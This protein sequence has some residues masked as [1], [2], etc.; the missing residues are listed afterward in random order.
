MG[1][2]IFSVLFGL[3]V[4]MAISAES[5][6]EDVKRFEEILFMFSDIW[7][8][9]PRRFVDLPSDVLEDQTHHP[10]LVDSMWAMGTQAAEEGPCFQ[11]DHKG[12]LYIKTR[13]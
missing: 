9:L 2:R 12:E 6:A 13:P 8:S 11:G 4:H 7:F 3:L 10:T 1:S 5:S